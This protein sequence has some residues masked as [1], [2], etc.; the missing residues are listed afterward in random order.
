MPELQCQTCTPE[1][2]LERGCYAKKVRVVD[3]DQD[4]R[5]EWDNPAPVPTTIDG[6][7]LYAC[8]RQH[9]RENQYWWSK[10]MMYYRAYDQGHLPNTG[11]VADQ[12]NGAIQLM[13]ILK[14]LFTEAHNEAQS[15]TVG[16][17]K[18]VQS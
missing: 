13:T 16:E 9:I 8:P 17:P 4:P 14:S 10:A 11:G 12:S 2:R 5:L 7:D 1:Q 3:E 6:E 15:R 18:D